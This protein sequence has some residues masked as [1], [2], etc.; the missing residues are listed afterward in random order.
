MC[1]TSAG[2]LH[3]YMRSSLDPC[4]NSSGVMG[5]DY[6]G[7]CQNVYK[8]LHNA[9]RRWQMKSGDMYALLAKISLEA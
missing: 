8:V 1:R 7:S 6:S 5:Q 9:S 4:P 3:G 2:H